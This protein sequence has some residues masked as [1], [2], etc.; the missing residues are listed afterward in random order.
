MTTFHVSYYK[1]L[2]NPVGHN[3][4]CLQRTIDVD[5]ASPVAALTLIEQH[6]LSFADCD[7]LEVRRLADVGIASSAVGGQSTSDHCDREIAVA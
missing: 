1:I 5:A 4:K 7:C 3:F 2:Q 6:G